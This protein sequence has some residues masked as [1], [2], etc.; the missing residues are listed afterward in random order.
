MTPG[1]PP[2]ID[3][4]RLRLIPTTVEH[5]PS[6]FPIWGN[7]ELLGHYLK[8]VCST[9][10]ECSRV[11][12]RM[13]SGQANGSGYRWSISL[14]QGGRII[15][16][17]GYHDWDREERRAELSYEVV[18]ERWGHGFATEAA[19]AVLDFGFSQMRLTT[20]VG[21]VARPNAPSIR[22]LERLGFRCVGEGLRDW[23]TRRIPFLTFHA[24]SPHA[25]GPA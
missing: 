15:G 7:P 5:A 4:L 10:E 1:E 6:L 16:S 9:V 21:R 11:V 17:L 3:T 22:V 23:G 24:T 18:P 19:A 25:S 8:D 14:R 20:V 12:E 13:L 2:P